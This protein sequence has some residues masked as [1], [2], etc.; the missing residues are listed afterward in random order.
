VTCERT[1]GGLSQVT[2]DNGEKLSAEVVLVAK[3]RGPRVDGLGLDR[4]G[5]QPTKKGIPV[6]DHCR[7]RKPVE[8]GFSSTS[9]GDGVWAVGDVT[10]VAG[11]THIADYQGQIV[12]ANILGKARTANYSDIPSVTFTDPEVASV[13]FSDASKAPKGMDVVTA[14]VDLSAGART[15]TY[16]KGYQGELCL[17]VDRGDK[18]LVGAWTVGPPAGEWIQFATLAI[19]A[20][21]PVSVLDDTILAFPTFTRLYLEPIRKLQ[22]EL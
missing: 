11:F 3:G 4:V 14:Q 18:V 19:R 16:D 13:G 10:G 15:E 12:S 22:K 20:K 8:S 5:I 17:L 9:A 1:D 2:L 6:D 21:V 7:A